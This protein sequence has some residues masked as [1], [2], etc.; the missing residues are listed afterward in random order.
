[1]PLARIITTSA[2]DSLELS[3]QLRSRGFRVETVAPDQIPSAPADLEVCLEECAPEDVLTKAA[4]VQESEDLWVFVAPGALD[5]RSR[6]MRVIP[7]TPQV[8]EISAREHA[9]AVAALTPTLEVAPVEVKLPETQKKTPFVEVPLPA[10]VVKEVVLAPVPEDEPLLCEIEAKASVATIDRVSPKVEEISTPVPIVIAE[11][12]VVVSAEIKLVDAAP[13]PVEVKQS[14]SPA[15][16]EIKSPVR[17]EAR[18]KASPK[19]SLERI[20]KLAVVQQAVSQ[21]PAVPQRVE[22][23]IVLYKPAPRKPKRRGPL[24]SYKVAFQTGPKLWRTASVTFAL[25]VLVGLVATVVAVHPSVPKKGTTVPN[26]AIFLPLTQVSA[27]D[28]TG[29]GSTTAANPVPKPNSIQSGS[30]RRSASDDGLI[31]KDT[32]VFY[33]RKPSPPPPTHEDKL[34]A[35][36]AK[37]PPP[38]TSG[39]KHYSDAN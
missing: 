19:P 39:V 11:P 25:L 30:H 23:K 22:P 27:P 34:P 32:V 1:M 26:P 28:S 10:V 6:P 8:V 18:Q 3:M 14:A 7:L 31:A 17:V 16:V 37:L 33:N 38:P 35:R 24:K 4:I 20:K 36:Q 2:D 29:R 9:A 5:E 15:P 21:I 13:L 12:A